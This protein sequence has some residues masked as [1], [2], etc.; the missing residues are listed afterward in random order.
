MYD[1]AGLVG[2][3]PS[4]I[5][6]TPRSGEEGR[7][8]ARSCKRC[9][10]RVARDPQSSSCAGVSL[11]SPRQECRSTAD[12]V[13]K[14]EGTNKAAVEAARRGCDEVD[15]AQTW[16]AAVAAYSV[17]RPPQRSGSIRARPVGLL[18]A[19]CSLFSSGVR[20]GD[21][22]VLFVPEQAG[23]GSHHQSARRGCLRAPGV[24]APR[25]TSCRERDTMSFSTAPR[26]TFLA[27][28]VAAVAMCAFGRVV[29]PAR[30]R[31]Q[32]V[33]LAAGHVRARDRHL[34]F[35]RHHVGGPADLRRRPG[36]PPH[37]SRA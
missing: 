35:W 11:P 19:R 37:R 7:D 18:F 33:H 5:S 34:A 4:Y 3:T 9:S 1:G 21:P 24:A 16:S 27:V 23:D 8:D 36:R 6:S 12:I 28:P 17:R 22:V 14:R 32:P 25:A 13:V 26:H 30:G 2:R 15:V 20:D 31:P 29:H 10:G